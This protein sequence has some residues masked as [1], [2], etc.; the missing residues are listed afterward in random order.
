MFLTAIFILPN[1]ID[2]FRFAKSTECRFQISDSD[3]QQNSNEKDATNN[4]EDIVLD[5]QKRSGANCDNVIYLRLP[6]RIT[7][8]IV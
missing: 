2:R 7:A 5:R 3:L 6:E 4:S 1:R 8:Y